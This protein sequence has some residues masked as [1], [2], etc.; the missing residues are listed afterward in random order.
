MLKSLS[1]LR[2]HSSG[3]FK[4]DEKTAD[5]LSQQEHS[6]I[7]LIYIKETRQYSNRYNPDAICSTKKAILWYRHFAPSQEKSL[8]W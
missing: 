8:P 2:I 7:V 4:F 3:P 1:N 6:E 5:S